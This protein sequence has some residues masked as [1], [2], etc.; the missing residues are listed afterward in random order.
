[1]RGCA[2]AVRNLS[3]DEAALWA[4]VMEN[5]RP[6][7]A[8]VA[9]RPKPQPARAMVAKASAPGPS[10]G[11]PPIGARPEPVRRGP[12]ITFTPAAEPVATTLDGSWDKRLARGLAVPDVT[13]DLHGHTLHSAH[14]LLDAALARAI[15]HGAR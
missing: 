13:V 7:R 6:L 3:P 4:R 14:D 2:V 1:M 8:A 10:N 9:A 12:P 5:V 11:L 15:A